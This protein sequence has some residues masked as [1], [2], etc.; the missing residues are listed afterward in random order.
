MLDRLYLKVVFLVPLKQHQDDQF[1]RSFELWTFPRVSSEWENDYIVIFQSGW[2]DQGS[3]CLP[4]PK[5]PVL[6]LETGHL[7]L[8]IGEF[9]I[10]LSGHPTP[11]CFLSVINNFQIVRNTSLWGGR[12]SRV[13]WLG[14]L[15]FKAVRASEFWMVGVPLTMGHTVE[16]KWLWMAKYYPGHKNPYSR[17]IHEADLQFDH[18]ISCDIEL[19]FDIDAIRGLCAS[20]ARVADRSRWRMISLDRTADQSH[21]YLTWNDFFGQGSRIMRNSAIRNIFRQ[22]YPHHCYYYFSW[23]EKEG[24]KTKNRTKEEE[25][26]KEGKALWVRRR[27][28]F[29][30]KSRTAGFE[31]ATILLCNY[32]TNNWCWTTYTQDLPLPVWSASGP[33]TL[34]GEFR[35]IY[36]WFSS[37]FWYKMCLY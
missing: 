8:V 1:W 34:S 9:G 16:N 23:K 13:N 2:R 24:N 17:E 36:D 27:E 12:K 15:S 29:E 3:K 18:V 33:G 5:L 32:D 26:E 28:N 30:R 31:P 21:E 19:R 35:W 4:D 20:R 22:E 25:I 14:G 6:V 10:I 37:L 11:F 7:L